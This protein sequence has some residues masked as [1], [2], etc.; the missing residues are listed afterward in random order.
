MHEHSVFFAPIQSRTRV[1]ATLALT[2]V[3]AGCAVGPD[4]RPPAITAT[5][6]YRI[7]E[8]T[9]GNRLVGSEAIPRQVFERATQVRADWYTVFGSHKLDTL[10]GAALAHSPTLAAGRARIEAAREAVN[11]VHGDLLPQVEA[12]AGDQRERANG[13]QLGVAS[14][15]FTNVFSVYQAQISASYDLDLFGKTERQ[16]ERRGAQL[17]QRRYEV[18]NIYVSLIDN[19]V[20]SAIAEAGVKSAIDIT[21]RMAAAQQQ[22]L[23]IVNQQIQLGAAISADAAQLRTQLARTRAAL[24]LLQKQRL[25]AVDR[26]AVLTGTAPGQFGD[27]GFT[28]AELKLPTK[29]PVSVPAQLVRQRPD[30]LAAASAVHAAS[31]QIGVATANLLPDISLSASYSRNGLSVGNLADPALAMFSLG[32]RIAA[33][34]FAGGRLRAQK[35]QAQDEYVAALADYHATS[36]LAFGQ[37][38]DSLRSLES[39]ARVLRAQQNALD[40]ARDSLDTVKVQLKNGTADYIALYLAQAQ[41]QSVELNYTGA[42]VTRYRDTADLFRA[43]GGGWWNAKSSSINAHTHAVDSAPMASASVE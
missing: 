29:L 17:N 18:L 33:P 32:A 34:V 10:I 22:S 24:G 27:P 39:D 42:Q 30:I 36:L 1:I 9:T 37:V 35:R 31:A 19:I 8:A 21:T 25:L 16:I 12:S 7:G 38:A 40:A 28:L 5:S 26:L 4:Y 20:A 15:M 43:L 3:L 41:Y 11:A 23:D 14:P 2:T 6:A 13:T